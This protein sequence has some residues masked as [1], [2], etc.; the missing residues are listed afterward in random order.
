MQY[1][2]T[3]Y[4]FIVRP[5]KIAQVLCVIEGGIPQLGVPPEPLDK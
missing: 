3:A 1:T 5:F 4:V 2:D